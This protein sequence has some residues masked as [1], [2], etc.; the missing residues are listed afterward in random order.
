MYAYLFTII[1]VAAT[2]AFVV[3]IISGIWPELLI[4]AGIALLFLW[5]VRRL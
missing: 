1:A 5:L 3:G 2:L 4:G